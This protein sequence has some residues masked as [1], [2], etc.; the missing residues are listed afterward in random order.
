MRHVRY[1]LSVR[2]IQH[3]TRSKQIFWFHAILALQYFAL[4]FG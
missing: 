4:F 3:T 1:S 2:Y